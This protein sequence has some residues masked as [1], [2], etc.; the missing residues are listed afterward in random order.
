MKH[1]TFWDITSCSPLKANRHC[2]GTYH[3]HAQRGRISQARNQHEA[4]ESKRHVT[5]KR[6]IVF[7]RL[8]SIIFQK[9]GL[10]T[11]ITM[12]PHIQS[13]FH[14]NSI[15]IIQ[16]LV[17]ILILNK[18]YN[19]IQFFV[20]RIGAGPEKSDLEPQFC[21]GNDTSGIKF[22]LQL[23]KGFFLTVWKSLPAQ[24]LRS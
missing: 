3:L 10:F 22:V 17:T 7:N 14:V 16:H 9:T 13:Q 21:T 15:I 1:P 19:R 20:L 2:G 8:H 24:R 11:S 18:N 23:E 12:E 5:P 4:I 6:R